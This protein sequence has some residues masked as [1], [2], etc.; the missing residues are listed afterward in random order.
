MVRSHYREK[1]S[2]KLTLIPILGTVMTRDKLACAPPDLLWS[3]RRCSD[4]SCAVPTPL[5]VL[6]PSNFL[7]KEMGT[8]QQMHR[9]PRDVSA[10]PA[11]VSSSRW[12]CAVTLPVGWACFHTLPAAP[13]G[14]DI[15]CWMPCEVQ[16]LVVPCQQQFQTCALLVNLQSLAEHVSV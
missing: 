11:K 14:W 13:K 15:R 10:T 5:P 8:S 16:Q 1:L 4:R 6:Y 3:S 7:K 2:S 12:L 9:D